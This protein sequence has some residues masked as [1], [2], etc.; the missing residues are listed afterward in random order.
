MAVVRQRKKGDADAPDA[1]DASSSSSS[2][3]PAGDGAVRPAA[4]ARIPR[5]GRAVLWTGCFYLFMFT[6]VWAF[7]APHFSPRKFCGTASAPDGPR[8][9]AHDRADIISEMVVPMFDSDDDD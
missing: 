4:K 2:P 1:A 9:R 6:F 3:A 7:C 5:L 8:A